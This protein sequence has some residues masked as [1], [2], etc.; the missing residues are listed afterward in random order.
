MKYSEFLE[1]SG[2][3]SNSLGIVLRDESETT[4]KSLL[5]KIKGPSFME[6]IADLHRVVLM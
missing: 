3:A 4:T 1:K 2:E 5:S 6:D